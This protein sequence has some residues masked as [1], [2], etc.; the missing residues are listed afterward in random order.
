MIHYYLSASPSATSPVNGYQGQLK[1]TQRG[2]QEII[3]KDN[4]N[5]RR[6]SA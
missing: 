5:D 4:A 1:M 2:V 6:G 3:T